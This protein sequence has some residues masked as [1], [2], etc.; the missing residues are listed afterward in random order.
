M[1]RF[2][3]IVFVIIQAISKFPFELK[4]IAANSIDAAYSISR[5]IAGGYCRRS[6]KKYLSYLNIALASFGQFHSSY[7]SFL[8]ADQINKTEYEQLEQ[9]HYKVENELFKLIESF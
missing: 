5:S 6:V 1:A 4:E 3:F 2:C 8:A 9:L 7:D